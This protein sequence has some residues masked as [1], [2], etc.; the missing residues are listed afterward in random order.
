MNAKM[1]GLAGV[2]GLLSLLLCITTACA[3]SQHTI[4]ASSNYQTKEVKIGN[5]DKIELLG[6]PTV[7]YTQSTNGKPELK[8]TG[9]DNLIDAIEC[10]VVNNVLTV[11][12]R[13][14][15]NIQFGVVGRLKV[16]VSSPSLNDVH[17]NGSGDVILMNVVKCTKLNLDLVGSGDIEADGIECTNDF[18]ATLQGS[19]DVT[20]KKGVQAANATL[21][22][23]GSGD[24]EINNLVAK[25]AIVALQGSGDLSVR[26]AKMG[27]DVNV[28]MAGS[29]DLSFRGIKGGDVSAELQGSGDLTLEGSAKQATLV[30]TNSGNL[31]AGNLNA[32][33]VDARLQGT[34]HISCAASG[35]LKCSINGSGEI[36]YKGNPSNVQSTGK[37]KPRRL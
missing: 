32:I 37:N 7:I 15:L 18:S 13:N 28:K 3:Q 6:S 16:M 31:D 33:D 36:G 5:F 29:G 14:N 27:G 23:V 26:S 25:S 30:L 11:K 19:G 9:S 24:L 10:K 2:M 34:G 8:I 4:K 1:K 12:Y 35:N 17:L 20:V 22:L 21:K